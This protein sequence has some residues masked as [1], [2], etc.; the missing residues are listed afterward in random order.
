MAARYAR[1]TGRVASASS[2]RPG[3]DEHCY[4]VRDSMRIRCH[5]VICGQVARA[6]I[7]TDASRNLPVRRSWAPSQT[8]LPGERTDPPRGD[9]ADRVSRSPVPAGLAQCRGH[10]KDFKT[11]MGVVPGSGIAADPGY[12]RR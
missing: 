7:G 2:L 12:R 6:S 11:G 5:G 3:G 8:H 1:A 4:P 9:G 10:P